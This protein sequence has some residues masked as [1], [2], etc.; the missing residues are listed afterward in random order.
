MGL[1]AAELITRAEALAPKLAERSASAEA[2]RR[3]PEATVADLDSAGLLSVC[4]PARFGGYEMDWDVLCEVGRALARGCASQS[5]VGCIYNDH[6]QMLGMFEPKAQEDVWTAN[7]EILTSASLD[8]AGKGAAADGGLVWSGHHRFCSGIDHASWMILGGFLTAIDGTQRRCFALMPKS[9]GKVLDDWQ[10][11]GLSGTGSKSFIVDKVFVP[12]HRVLDFDASDK[13]A[14][15]GCLVPGAAAVFRMP[16][17]DIAPSGFAAIATGAA[18]GFLGDYIAYTSARVSRG[19]A[20]AEFTG[21]QIAIGEASVQVEAAWRNCAALVS[22]V[23]GDLTA[24]RPV[25]REARLKVKLATAHGCQT[26]LATAQKL[27]NQAG[28]RALFTDNPMQRRLRDLYAVAAHRSTHW[29][30]AAAAVG[31]QMLGA[32]LPKGAAR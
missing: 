4:R 1:T 9:E 19:L 5:W 30:L 25:T 16:R 21:T 18:E 7:R 6:S 26:A 22:G 3:C 2:A 14:S 32:E 28:G 17:H 11:A 23:M 12:A 10:V 24:G 8:P 13:G 27:F 15:P 29:E 20:M 31:A